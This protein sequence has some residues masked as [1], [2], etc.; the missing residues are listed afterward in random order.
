[1]R[2]SGRASLFKE[3]PAQPDDTV[4]SIG[5]SRKLVTWGTPDKVAEELRALP[6]ERGSSAPSSTP[7]TTGWMAL[8]RRSMELTAEAVMPRLAAPA[9]RR[10]LAPAR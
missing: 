6:E 10:K 4:A 5:C 9:V 2:R 1:M 8:A 7:A 3:D